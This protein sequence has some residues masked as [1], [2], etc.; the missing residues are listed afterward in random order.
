MFGEAITF[1]N[2]KQHVQ[3]S[4]KFHAPDYLLYG[5]INRIEVQHDPM[6][7][8]LWVGIITFVLVIGLFLII[9]R[10]FLFPWKITIHLKKDPPLVIRARLTENKLS[11]LLS[12][13]QV[14]TQLVQTKKKK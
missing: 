14:P 3:F 13:P 7:W 4:S 11:G 2:A 12:F 8:L 6:N 1:N 10:A 5:Q 9:A